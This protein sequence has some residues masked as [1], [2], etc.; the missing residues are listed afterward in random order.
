MYRRDLTAWAPAAAALPALFM[1]TSRPPSSLRQRKPLLDIWILPTFCGA[2]RS[3]GNVLS[4][5]KTKKTVMRAQRV[6]GEHVWG[7]SMSPLPF[8]SVRYWTTSA[9][10]RSPSHRLWP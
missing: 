3:E 6:H 5:Q 2:R 4:K 1:S 10:Q 8:R 9:R 7:A